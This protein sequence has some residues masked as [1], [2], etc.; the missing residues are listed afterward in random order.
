MPRAPEHRGLR[1]AGAQVIDE[2]GVDAL[3]TCAACA[4]QRAGLWRP[5][6]TLL[7]T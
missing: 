1:T 7:L 3:L 5:L 4:G 2:A 6:L